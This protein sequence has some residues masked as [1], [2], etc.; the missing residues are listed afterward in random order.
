M[1]TL[2][3]PETGQSAS[4]T[5]APG[6]GHSCLPENEKRSR[7]HPGTWS[8]GKKAVAAT[9]AVAFVAGGWALFRP[10]RLF[11]NQTV[12]ETLPS[13]GSGATTLVSQG[14]FSSG[15]HP[16]KGTAGLYQSGMN[17]Y[18]LRLTNFSTSNGPDVH[19]YAVEGAQGNDDTKIKGGGF[20][21]LGSIKGNIGDQNYTLP[22][23]F[24]AHKYGAVSIW[25]KRF[26]VNFGAASLK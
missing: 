22:A 18:V 19:V 8:A 4:K 23:N 12:S 21:D 10:E 6:Q 16:T 9:L 5:Q 17:G 20:L 3:A 7:F 1:N 24:D 15:V 13:S 11:V 26:G 14:V 2:H 25:C